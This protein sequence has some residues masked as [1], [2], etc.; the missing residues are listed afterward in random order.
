MPAMIKLKH[1]FT[2]CHSAALV[3]VAVMLS[4]PSWADSVRKSYVDTAYGQVHIRAAGPSKTGAKGLPLVL[5][6]P[7]PYSSAYYDTVLPYLGEDRQTIAMDTPGYGGSDRP[8]QPLLMSEIA[9]RM[10]AALDAIGFSTR[11]PVAVGGYH[12]GAY[13]ASELAV[14]RPDLVSTVILIGVPYWDD[15][16]RE[17]NRIR[18]LVDKPIPEDGS[19]LSEKWQFS[20][21]NRN[22][23]VPVSR[24]QELFTESL[25]AGR[26]V[27]WAYHAVVNYDPD[28]Q[29]PRIEQPVLVLNTHGSLQNETRA[30]V[31]LL[32]NPTLVEVPELARGIFEEGPELLAG[33]ITTYLSQFHSGVWDA[34]E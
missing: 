19:H 11:E 32:A 29:L 1:A 15:E 24:A 12:T 18:L 10:G 27:W 2:L 9:V 20:V 17:E 21:L 16:K 23:V 30:I 22:P 26:T 33:H 4:S 7:N 31:P 28:V 34:T 13:I 14:V 8:A 5:F 3:L 25:R 6:H